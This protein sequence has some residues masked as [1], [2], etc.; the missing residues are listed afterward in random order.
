MIEWDNKREWLEKLP[1]KSQ[2][3]FAVFCVKQVSPTIKHTEYY[4]DLIKEI[5]RWIEVDFSLEDLDDT[6]LANDLESAVIC[7]YFTAYY[8]DNSVDYAMDAASFATHI[9]SLKQKQ[10]EYLRELYL[11]TLPEEQRDSWL[12][13][14][15]L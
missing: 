2:V 14:A 11:E 9:G 5:E 13:Q 1:H 12:V 3:R 7:A 10:V 6:R 15:C 4:A 8:E